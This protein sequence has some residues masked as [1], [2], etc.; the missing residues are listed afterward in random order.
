MH[1]TVPVVSRDV[2]GLRLG[3]LDHTE[4]KD[5]M[6]IERCRSLAQQYLAWIDRIENS[7]ARDLPADDAA[8]TEAGRR[9]VE[10]CRACHS[11]IHT[12]IDLLERDA[13][14]REAFRLMNRAMLMQQM[15]SSLAES[16]RDWLHDM[17]ER[18][19]T[20]PE[21]HG[22][23]ARGR[24]WRPFQL[25]FILMNL[26]S[27]ADPAS[28]D[29]RVVDLVW[30]PTGGGK[31][32]AYLGLAGFTTFLRR[33][34]NPGNGGM[35]VFMRYTL[36]LLTADQFRRA[37][38]LLCACEV[39]R[40]GMPERLGRE[41]FAVGLW[42]GFEVTPN[43]EDDA[44]RKLNELQR[45][46][47]PERSHPFVLQ[48]C[49][50]CG[51]RLGV[52][53]GGRRRAPPVVKGFVSR[54]RSPKFRIICPDADCDFNTE[55]GIPVQIVDEAIYA[56]PPTLVIGT[57][58]KFATVVFRP[59][60]RT[61]FGID[62]PGGPSPPELI[63]QDELH[64][65]SGPLGS[66]VGH[67]ETVIDALCSAEAPVK[68]VASTATISHAREQIRKL[69]GRGFFLFP[70][71]GLSAGDSFFAE[72]RPDVTGRA[73]VGF[74]GTANPSHVTSQ[75]RA[76]AAL[77]QAPLIAERDGH[78]PIDPYFTLIAYYNSL[79]ELGQAA[80]LI[81]ADIREY[82]NVVWDRMGIRKSDVAGKG[83]DPRRFVHNVVELTSRASAEEVTR[84][85]QRL[86]IPYDGVRPVKA[87]D[88]CLATNMIQVG[89]DV[90]RLGLMTI[91]GQPK[92]TSEYIQA[93]SRIGR[94]HPGLV[95]TNYNPAKPR[96]RSQYE[97]FRSYHQSFYRYVEP[98]SVTPFAVPVRER[99]LHSLVVIL[100][101]MW[102]DPRTREQPWPFPPESLIQGVRNAILGRIEG[103]EDSEVA[104]ARRMIEE[105]LDDWRQLEP[106]RYGNFDVRPDPRVPL[107]VPAGGEWPED[108]NGRVYEVPTSMRNVDRECQVRTLRRYGDR[109]A[110]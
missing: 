66:M 19:L 92:T 45:Q 3:F 68:I 8:I 79:R 5:Q 93:S 57:V 96:D 24:G 64:L 62:A 21:L 26:G 107:L 77:L 103:M 67:Y 71:Q 50:W 60:A 11:R 34:R 72:E 98:T 104:G 94:Q 44:I 39:I 82:L 7:L 37:A 35:T 83:N 52:V 55:E 65:I 73:Y 85:L 91:T 86:R 78:G 75:V 102:G 110:V 99:A 63:I 17:P 100:T 36:R 47:D 105:F 33:L 58:D 49:P 27:M 48:C 20:R 97:H 70:P 10:L 31:T 41:R 2:E 54:P 90:L 76:M 80:T 101:R 69:Y 1:E 59:E 84:N 81:N 16:P 4:G 23:D 30:F 95:V 109:S 6:L 12:G 43:R 87:V 106:E 51:I 28:Q 89:L 53:A 46:G 22:A 18:P 61:L 42:A 13:T 15:H 32:E 88:T 9:H 40:R 38:S 56:Q 14:V 74:M 25:A 108:W 29:R